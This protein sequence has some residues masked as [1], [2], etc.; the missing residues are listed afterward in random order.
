[1]A[2]RIRQDDVDVVRE[3]T[4]I[5]KLVS[6]YLTL[7]R[8]GADAF[9]G[10]CPFH[11]EKTPSFSVSPSKGLY[12]CFGCDAGGDAIAFLR[13]VERLEFAEAVER[14]ARDAGVTL[15]YEGDSPAAQRAAS[16]RQLLHRANE[17]AFAAYHRELL[18]S[19]EGERARS[20]LASRGIDRAL[21]EGFEIG[22]APKAHD[23]LVRALAPKGISAEVLVESGLALRDQTSGAVRDRF[24]GR[25]TFPVRDLS[26]R[27]IGIGARILPDER[28]DGPKYLNSPETP[29]YRKAETL[30]NLHRAKPS[31]AKS[32]ELFVVEGY[33][34]VIALAN[35]GI[36]TA[37]ATCGTALGEGHFRLASRFA[38]RMV[39]AFDSDEAGARAAERAFAFVENFPVQ[40]VVLIL[41]DGM[42]PADL[43]T[44]RGPDVLGELAAGALPLVEY[45]LFRT[46]GRHDLSTVEGQSRAVADAL[47][48]IEGLTEPVRRSRYAH[49]LAELTGVS[50]ASVGDALGRRLGGRPAEVAETVKRVSV[51]QKVE[52]ELLKLLARD[53]HLYETIEPK[54]TDRHFRTA[55]NRKL[56]TMLVASDGDVRKVVG[57]GGDPD[58][59]KALS[60][61]V[62]EPIDGAATIEYA[63]GL[64][65]RLE[66]W[67]LKAEINDVRLRLQKKNPLTDPEYEAQFE[68]LA[69]LQGE[70]RRLHEHHGVP[71]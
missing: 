70:L 42:D 35:A 15:R 30:Y 21:A 64:W 44:E 7:K 28:E 65:S 55:G 19:Q 26:G 53:S 36:E 9:V 43:V 33:T 52:R 63:E 1:M 41:P 20:Y 56:F 14:L 12:H 6:G 50:E 3:R 67:R 11:T 40:P 61:L 24:R 58:A 18:E 69:R 25:I 46:V 10:L 16:H 45:M 34:D 32:G 8:A 29:I 49:L 2:G 71:V 5:V 37:V 60:G 4:D 31:I 47:P 17:E 59:V 51:Q 48:V 66:G 23:F 13:E 57:D 62:L 27:A 22:Y 68:R 38:Q 39:L 54:T